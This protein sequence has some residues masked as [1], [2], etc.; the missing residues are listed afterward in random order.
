M[1]Q[2]TL[3]GLSDYIAQPRTHD[4]KFSHEPLECQRLILQHLLSGLSL[5]VSQAHRLFFTH[6]LR[7][8]I[9]RLRKTHAIS[10][11]WETDSRGRRYKAYFIKKE[12][13]KNE[14]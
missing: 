11:R 3:F 4:G 7:K 9:S 8:V 6:D 12:D 13:L 10:D 14:N 1:E 5:T 2:Q